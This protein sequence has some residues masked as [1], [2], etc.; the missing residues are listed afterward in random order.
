M[1]QS[2]LNPA[3]QVNATDVVTIGKNA[4]APVDLPQHINPEIGAPVT[5]LRDDCFLRKI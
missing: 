3:P 2:A 4:K 5:T 1:C